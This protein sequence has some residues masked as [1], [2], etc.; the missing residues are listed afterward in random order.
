MTEKEKEFFEIWTMLIKKA[1]KFCL[2]NK[3]DIG[4]SD[5]EEGDLRKI[6]ACLWTKKDEQGKKVEDAAPF[7]YPKLKINTKTG[8][9]Y[10]LLKKGRVK[11]GQDPTL[12]LENVEGQWCDLRANLHFESIFVNS[13]YVTIQVKVLEATIWPHET[14]EHSIIP[15]EEESEEEED[16]DQ[17]FEY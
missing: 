14:V 5:L 2:E 3:V 9:V 12:E 7:L 16:K 10:T 15:T 1:K 17:E 4:C 11:K 6:G 13:M 8:K